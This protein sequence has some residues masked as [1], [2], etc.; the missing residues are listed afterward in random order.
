MAAVSCLA[1][2]LAC[3]AV[4]TGSQQNCQHVQIGGTFQVPLQ[5]KL[6]PSESLMWKHNGARIFYR[7]A[8]KIL[9]GSKENVTA[10]GSL[11]LKN[12][13]KRHEGVY[14]AEV[15]NA[16][17]EMIPNI[18]SISLCVLAPVSKPTV[19][20]NCGSAHVTFT[21]QTTEKSIVWLQNEKVMAG[22]NNFNLT[23]TAKDSRA[24]PIRCRVSNQVSE[25]TSD[26]H[27][28]Q[29]PPDGLRNSDSEHTLLGLEFW[30]MIIIL[31][32]GGGFVLLL[33]IILVV[34][35]VCARRKKSMQVKDEEELRLTWAH[36]E[37][38]RQQ[39]N[40][41]GAAR[42]HH[43]RTHPQKTHQHSA[44]N[45]GPRSHCS[46]KNREHQD[47]SKGPQANPRRPKQSPRQPSGEQA[48]PLPQPRRQ[49]A[50]SPR[51]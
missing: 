44:G 23:L 12:I 37:Q 42:Q 48:P 22:Q 10:S 19:K 15:F 7:K 11:S 21:C 47:A 51:A 13:E 25:S 4:T 38:P 26:A 40:L 36:G 49:G 17:G 3:F 39:N 35:C 28:P 16:D 6:Q 43:P 32:A 41:S 2:L 31:S 20:E 46:K 18:K 8:N 14:A 30:T 50:K 29:C 34:C 1:L 33:I 5:H 27:T 45:T 24:G 9:T